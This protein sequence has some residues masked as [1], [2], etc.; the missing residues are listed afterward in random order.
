MSSLLRLNRLL[1]DDR[2]LNVIVFI[3]IMLC[4]ISRYDTRAQH[5][6]QPLRSKD[7]EVRAPTDNIATRCWPALLQCCLFERELHSS[8]HH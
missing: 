1:C 7:S 8:K 6:L 3:V 5:S 2:Q 4:T